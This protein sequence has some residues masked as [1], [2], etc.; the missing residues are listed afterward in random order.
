MFD[1][2]KKNHDLIKNNGS[3]AQMNFDHPVL[4]VRRWQSAN[5][6]KNV[7]VIALKKI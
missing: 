1:V 6:V 3:I 2:F 5:F 7:F 4:R